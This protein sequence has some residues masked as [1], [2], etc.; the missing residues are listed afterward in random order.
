MIQFKSHPI[1]RFIHILHSMETFPLDPHKFGHEATSIG[2]VGGQ[3]HTNFYR[4]LANVQIEKKVVH[5]KE[6]R[7]IFWSLVIQKILSRGF[8]VGHSSILVSTH[9]FIPF[10]QLMRPSGCL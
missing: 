2:V 5:F 9:K 6:G 4:E 3:R 10:G 8:L 7:M 1:E